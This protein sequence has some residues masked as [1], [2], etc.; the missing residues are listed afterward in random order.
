MA[1]ECSSHQGPV[2]D[3]AAQSPNR[4]ICLDFQLSPTILK[5]RCKGQH[6]VTVANSDFKSGHKTETLSMFFAF[7][8]TLAA[9]LILTLRFQFPES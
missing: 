3:A 5:T 9:H 2:R 8:P 7:F 6:R 1:W 4:Q